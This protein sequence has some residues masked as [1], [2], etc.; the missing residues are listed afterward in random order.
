GAY[1]FTPAADYS[2]TVPTV[3][4]T[5]KEDRENGGSIEQKLTFE[6]AKVSDEPIL[7][8]EKVLTTP[9]DAA[10]A[11]DLALPRIKDEGTG[12]GNNDYSER[13]GEI[14]LTIGGAGKEGVTLST[15]GDKALV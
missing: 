9:E 5:V 10:V 13:L 12:T 14:T 7:G 2:G 3:T 11:L 4:Y 1:R 6:I 8:A 15:T